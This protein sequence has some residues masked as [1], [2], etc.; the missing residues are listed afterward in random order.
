M[1]AMMMTAMMG[2]DE[3]I[4]AEPFHGEGRSECV[5]GRDHHVTGIVLLITFIRVSICTGYQ[6]YQ[7]HSTRYRAHMWKLQVHTSSYSKKKYVLPGMYCIIFQS[8]SDDCDID[9]YQLILILP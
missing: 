9:C 6:G 3:A 5:L 8:C 2:C 4:A 7:H 1:I